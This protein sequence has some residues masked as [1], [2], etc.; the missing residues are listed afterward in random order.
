MI[1]IKLKKQLSIITSVDLISLLRNM[2]LMKLRLW[3][4]FDRL[5]RLSIVLLK[6]NTIVLISE[7]K[8]LLEYVRRERKILDGNQILSLQSSLSEIIAYIK[9]SKAQWYLKVNI[10][11]HKH[12]YKIKNLSP[13]TCRSLLCGILDAYGF[14]YFMENISSTIIK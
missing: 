2:K 9:P 7:L 1:I 6:V 11:L 3:K 12:I 13:Q 10:S 8:I 5:L 4:Q 14:I